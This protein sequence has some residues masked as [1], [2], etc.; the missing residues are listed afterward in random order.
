MSEAI[1]RRATTWP[2]ALV[3]S[4]LAGCAR[5]PAT[6]PQVLQGEWRTRARLYADRSVTFEA[7][8]TLRLGLGEQG[9]EVVRIDQFTELD[10]VNGERRFELGYVDSSG[11]RADLQLALVSN[12]GVLYVGGNRSV[13]WRREEGVE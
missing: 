9:E 1:L 3:V 7:P 10:S 2:L 8:A 12:R 6:L 4:L 11:E 5:P 13:A